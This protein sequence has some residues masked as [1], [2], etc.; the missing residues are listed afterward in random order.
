MEN[1]KIVRAHLLDALPSIGHGFGTRDAPLSQDGMASLR[2]V[3]SAR[4]LVTDQPGCAGE[5]DALLT[6]QPGLAVSVRTADCLPILL[7]DPEHGAVAAVHAG[8]RGTAARIV[9]EAIAKMEREFETN[10]AHLLAAIGPGIGVCCY[11]VGEDVAQRFGLH[12]A[13]YVDLAQEN[14]RQLQAAGVSDARIDLL[15]LCTFCDRRFH[16]WRRDKDQAGRT[17]S[18]IKVG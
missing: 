1:S 16:S 6:A 11:Q 13:G 17:I 3:H 14:R 7:A 8:W 2:Q 9:Q 15:G 5:G 4:C 12:G 18:F 10:P